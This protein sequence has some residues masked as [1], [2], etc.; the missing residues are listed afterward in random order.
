MSRN[1]ITSQLSNQT[2]KGWLVVTEDNLAG[3]PTA[4]EVPL[5]LR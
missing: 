4:D 1:P 5:R 3:R 2:A